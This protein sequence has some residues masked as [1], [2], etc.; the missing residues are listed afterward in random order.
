MRFKILFLFFIICAC[1]NAQSKADSSTTWLNKTINNDFVENKEYLNK[2]LQYDFSKLWVEEKYHKFQVG[3]IGNNYQRIQIHYF[4]IIKNTENPKIYFVYGKS[5]VKTNICEFLGTIE[6]LHIKKYKLS[7]ID[8]LIPYILV[9][10]YEYF[11]NQNKNHTG[12]FKGIST[13][14]FYVS[15]DNQIKYD[16]ITVVADGYSN[17]EFVGVWQGYKSERESVCNWGDFRV[18]FSHDLDIGTGEFWPNEKYLKY[19]WDKYKESHKKHNLIDEW[20]K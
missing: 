14:Y 20:W 10:K 4:S 2:F 9:S 17:N 6:L 7:E 3:F 16:D 15:P 18:P 1:G 12:K 11:E 19:G 5:K 8:T 13:L